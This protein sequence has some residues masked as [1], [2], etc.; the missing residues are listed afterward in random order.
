M[1]TKNFRDQPVF[2]IREIEDHCLNSMNSRKNLKNT[3][4]AIIMKSLNRER[5]Y[6]GGE[7]W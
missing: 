3:K 7:L 5:I 2:A 6:E 4:T 1:S